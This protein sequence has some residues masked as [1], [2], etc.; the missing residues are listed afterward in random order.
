MLLLLVMWPARDVMKI[1]FVGAAEVRHAQPGV[2]VKIVKRKEREFAPRAI[3]SDA[4]GCFFV[5]CEKDRP[6][7]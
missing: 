3:F 5:I 1:V 7:P 2:C 6:R 4:R